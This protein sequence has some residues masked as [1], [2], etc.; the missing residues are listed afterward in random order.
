MGDY[1]RKSKSFE[2]YGKK[3]IIRDIRA[4]TSE[5]FE[6][7]YKNHFIHV[8]IESGGAGAA[9]IWV[10]AP[11]GGYIADG[12]ASGKYGAYATMGEAIQECLENILHEEK[13]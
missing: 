3:R 1:K 6:A 12:Y 8:Q 4:D 11:D 9:Y 7:Y 2:V 13:I 10:T 5:D